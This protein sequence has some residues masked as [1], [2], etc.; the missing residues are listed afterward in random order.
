MPLLF[1]TMGIFYLVSLS[2][3]EAVIRKLPVASLAIYALAG[4]ILPSVLVTLFN[5]LTTGNGNYILLAVVAPGGL[6]GG[7]L[8]GVLGHRARQQ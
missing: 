8:L 2:L 6:A 7:A 4:A 3:N 5:L 1:A